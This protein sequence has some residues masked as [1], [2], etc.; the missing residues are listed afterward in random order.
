ME[1]INF[2]V[3]IIEASAGTG[4]TSKLTE[5]FLKFLDKNNPCE[6]I[7]KIMAV[8]FSEK[9]ALEMKEKIL[10]NIF[11]KIYP[12]LS[13]KDKLQLENALFNLRIST[14]HSFCQFLLRKFSFYIG[15][16][17]FFKIIQEDETEMLFSIAI[18]KFLN[19]PEGENYF[20]K[21]TKFLKLGSII[22][23]LH[24]MKKNHPHIFIGIPEEKQITKEFL[25]LFHKVSEIH[26]QL[27]EENSTLDFDDLEIFTY[28][29]LTE[30]SNAL[31]VLEDFD[32]KINFL[33]VDEF[34]DTNILQW[35]ILVKLFEEWISGYGAKA[36]KGESY[37]IFIVGDKKQSIYSF[38]G[39]ESDIFDRAKDKLKNY[40]KE[41]PLSIN[42]RSSSKILDFVNKIFEDT[43]PWD[44]QKLKVSD[45]SSYLTS[46]TIEINILP[47][48]TEKKKEYEWICNKI[49]QMKFEKW[50]VWDKKEKKSRDI[51]Y[52]DIAILMRKRG[53]NLGLLEKV[54][55]DYGIPY[56]M[57]GGI[58]F[59]QEPE[60]LFLLFLIFSFADITDTL[61]L[62]NLK[63]SIYNIS[64]EKIVSW[65]EKIK[66]YNLS[67]FLEEILKEINFWE[68]MSIQQ[69]ANV[70]KFL[71]LIQSQEHLPIFQIAQNLREFCSRE[72]EPKADIFSSKEDGVRILT[73]HHAKGLEFP[74]VFLINLEDGKTGLINVKI[75]YKKNLNTDFPYSF[76]LSKEEGIENYRDSFKKLI[77]EE[78]ERILY[79]ALTRASQ[80][81]FISGLDLPNG[82][83]IKR[84]KKVEKDFPPTY[85]EKKGEIE[86]EKEKKTEEVIIKFLK[87]PISITS[88]SEEFSEEYFSSEKQFIGEVI[89]KILYEISTGK[90]SCD[91]SIMK[92]RADFYY[93]KRGFQDINIL[94]E[95]YEILLKIN[96]SQKIKEIV[97]PTENSY[98]ELPFIIEEK[99]TVYQGQIDRII[100][101]DENV[102]VYDYKIYKRENIEIYKKQLELYGIAARKIFPLKNIVKNILFIDRGEIMEF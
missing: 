32:E 52:S 22:K 36:D 80:Y 100:I 29:L 12:F 13:D 69:K 89:H 42:Y 86:R 95:I 44:K 85:Y 39:A 48:N 77:T 66:S 15:I 101:K 51:E 92:E 7:K 73:I 94:N 57:V 46:P 50:K 67:I 9:S 41:E 34:Q 3:T 33:L 88:F 37:G 96:S 78:E 17:P 76:V 87:E 98:S 4:K 20:L 83:W 81:L 40:F 35:E 23:Y 99:G 14:I 6:S 2:S 5:Q 19:S 11:E 24:E 21:L 53:K 97:L 43:S 59:Y 18:G 27:K 63:N 45:V 55:T 25:S 61:S 28:N 1:K 102:L 82:L 26:K 56:I 68:G 62:W 54:L 47:K 74:A 65:R 93:K 90:I 49:L 38:R 16:D 70:E 31:T 30:N 72:K 84:I 58:G 8:T 10:T 75:Y 64:Y 60:I 71:M 79:V 91:F